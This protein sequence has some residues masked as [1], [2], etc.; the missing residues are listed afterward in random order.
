MKEVL[1]RQVFC[2]IKIIFHYLLMNHLILT[3]EG[4]CR[5]G[6]NWKKSQNWKKAKL[7]KEI[8]P[9]KRRKNR[10]QKIQHKEVI[11][12]ELKEKRLS[13]RLKMWKS[14]LEN[15]TSQIKMM[16]LK[17]WRMKRIFLNFK[18]YGWKEIRE[19]KKEFKC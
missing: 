17:F 19:K 1:Y 6:K 14:G 18:K 15:K 12:W 9:N 7:Q 13:K 4:Y 3:L 16:L 8:N 11:L 2:K 5:K 10:S